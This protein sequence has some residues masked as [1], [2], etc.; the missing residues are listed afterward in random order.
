MSPSGRQVA[1]ART[2]LGMPRRQLAARADIS[3]PTLRRIEGREGAGRALHNNVVAVATALEAEGI[4]FSAGDNGT[5]VH[6]K[7]QPGRVTSFEECDL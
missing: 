4:A 3:L 5:G 6:L 1:A 2:L 7:R